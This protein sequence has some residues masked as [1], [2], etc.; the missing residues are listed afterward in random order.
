MSPKELLYI[1]DGK[2]NVAQGTALYRRRARPRKTDKSHLHTVCGDYS[3]QSAQISGFRNRK[4]TRK[5]FFGSVQI[6]LKGR[7]YYAG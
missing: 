7:K 3:G 4:Q 6:A 1:E 5:Y 2:F